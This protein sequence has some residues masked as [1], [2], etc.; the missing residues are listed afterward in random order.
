[1]ACATSATTP[2]AVAE[3]KRPEAPLPPPPTIVEKNAWPATPLPTRNERYAAPL[4]P[5]PPMLPAP[6]PVVPETPTTVTPAKPP[7]QLAPPPA[8]S[9]A[10]DSVN[11]PPIAGTAYKPTRR[12]FPDITARAE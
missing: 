12:S 2:K 3:L 9:K 6:A 11:I 5:K 4:A 7:V 1:V 10:D 8:V